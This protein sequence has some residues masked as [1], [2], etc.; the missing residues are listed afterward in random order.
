MDAVR[1]NQSEVDALPTKSNYVLVAPNYEKL[2]KTP[3]KLGTRKQ[4]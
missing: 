3:K 4:N 1:N 2:A